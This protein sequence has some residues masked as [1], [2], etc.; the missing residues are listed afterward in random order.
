[1]PDNV[2]KLKELPMLEVS[3]IKQRTSMN[4]LGVEYPGQ[5]YKPTS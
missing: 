3:N 5:A 4:Y 2:G 1:M